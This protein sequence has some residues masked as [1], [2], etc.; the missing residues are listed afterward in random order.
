MNNNFTDE[1]SISLVKVWH[2][3]KKKYTNKKIKLDSSNINDNLFDRSLTT[4][5]P[6]NKFYKRKM[7]TSKSF[8]IIRKDFYGEYDPVI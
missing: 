8:N 4:F 1:R 6:V 3:I 5:F 7:P 2:S